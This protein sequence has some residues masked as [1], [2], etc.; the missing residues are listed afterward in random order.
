MPNFAMSLAA[1]FAIWSEKPSR[2]MFNDLR[3]SVPIISR[4]LPSNESWI[5]AAI[6]RSAMFRK[7][8]AAR[9]IPSGVLITLILAT[10]STM[11]E[12]KSLVGTGTLVLM[13]TEVCPRK[14]L[15]TRSSPGMRKPPFPIRIRGCRDKPLMI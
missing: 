13:S 9:R 10:A 12:M 14:T 3:S 1:F 15:S 6:S 8:L 4:M 5:C 11:T 2:S 7:F